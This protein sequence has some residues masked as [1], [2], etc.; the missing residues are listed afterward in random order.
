MNVELIKQAKDILEVM[1]AN[2][3]LSG[4]DALKSS[5]TAIQLITSAFTKTDMSFAQAS[6]ILENNLQRLQ[7]MSFDNKADLDEIIPLVM[8][9]KMAHS[10]ISSKIH[11]V[12]AYLT[13]E[14]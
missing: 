13:D 11:H 7:Q 4:D 10:C 1:I 2:E 6:S 8:N 12:A 14:N 9:S 3:S 5:S